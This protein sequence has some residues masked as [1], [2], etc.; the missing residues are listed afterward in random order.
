VRSTELTDQQ[1]SELLRVLGP[2][3]GYLTRM[4]RRMDKLAFPHDDMLYRHV[5]EAQHRMQGLCMELHYL[6]C[7]SGVGRVPRE[8]PVE[9]SPFD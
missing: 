5:V 9:K 7:R 8:M 1:I 3:T 2:T 4:V 6:S